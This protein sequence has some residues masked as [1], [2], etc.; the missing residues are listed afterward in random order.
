MTLA[1]VDQGY[2]GEKTGQVARARGIDFDLQVAKLPEANAALFCCQGDGLSSGRL[3]GRRD[4]NG[5][6]LR[7]LCNNSCRVTCGCVRSC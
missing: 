7:S 1:Y 5:Q 6:G 3:A 2:T 4:F